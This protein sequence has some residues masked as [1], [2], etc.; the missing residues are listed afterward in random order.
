M[1]AT[2]RILLALLLC[3]VALEASAASFPCA[4]AKSKVEKLICADPVLS[5]LD[6][7][8]AAL[9]RKANTDW[10]ATAAG[11]KE[12]LRD[13]RD[14][15][16]D[17]ECL[18]KAYRERIE[19]LKHWHDPAPWSQ[20]MLG[21]YVEYHRIDLCCEEKQ[22]PIEVEDCLS[23]TLEP[24]GKSLRLRL[25]TIQANAHSCS[26]DLP[27]RRDGAG[28]RVVPEDGDSCDL[29]VRAERGTLVVEDPES[30]CQDYCGAR[31]HLDGLAYRRSQLRQ[32]RCEFEQ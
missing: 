8:L 17:N 31:A 25:Q 1:E 9:F 20:D 13:I 6:E 32:G 18:A 28:Y 11:Q 29:F 3:L 14:R 19:V 23:I 24:D 12:W 22:E 27:V 21:R 30:S 10:D 16:T 15:C 2:M 5:K 7:D 4:K 26:V